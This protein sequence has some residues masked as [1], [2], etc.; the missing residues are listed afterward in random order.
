[1]SAADAMKAAQDTSVTVRLDGDDLV[2]EAAVPPPSYVLDLL[3]LHKAGVVAMLR[4]DKDGWSIEEWQAL[5]DERAGI[6]EFDGGLPR[7]EAEALAFEHC[8]AEWLMRHPVRSSSGLCLGCG[9]GGEQQASYCRSAP[10]LVDTHG[11]TPSV[12]QHGMRA[13][14]Q[15][16]L[17]HCPRWAFARTAQWKRVSQCRELREIVGFPETRRE[18][19]I[20]GIGRM[21]ESTKGQQRPPHLWRPGQ[22]GNLAGRPKGSR[23]RLSEDFVAALFDDFQDHGA[24]AIAACR[25][26]KPD[27]YVRVIASLMPRDV[28]FS[29][30]HYD[31]L[32]DAELLRRLRTVTELAKPLLIEVTDAVVEPERNPSTDGDHP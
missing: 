9:H 20:R 12:G 4:L 32:S 29:V 6:A 27:V 21:I 18:Y 11:F 30:K 23:N 10:K 2:L 17:A 3:L 16:R 22:S 24:A 31:E 25:A 26:E 7:R 8:V 1:V 14:R 28:N 19:F 5:Y 13:A 15:R